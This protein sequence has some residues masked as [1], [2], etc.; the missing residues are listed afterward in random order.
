MFL[1]EECL[2][3]FIKDFPLT[4]MPMVYFSWLA[5]QNCQKMV[6]DYKIKSDI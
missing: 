6:N 2:S 1:F 5:L 4:L 3:L